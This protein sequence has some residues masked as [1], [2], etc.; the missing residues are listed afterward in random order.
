[1]HKPGSKN[2]TAAVDADALNEVVT[3]LCAQICFLCFFCQVLSLV[4]L[5]LLV[6]VLMILLVL[7]IVVVLENNNNNGGEM[8]DA[9]K[10]T[11]TG[12]MY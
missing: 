4:L 9:M 2:Y 12:P 3:Y 5:V 10:K 7:V 1:M 11:T 8:V 6:L